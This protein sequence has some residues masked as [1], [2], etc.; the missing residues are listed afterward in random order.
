MRGEFSL[1]LITVLAICFASAGSAG[2]AG[3]KS[4]GKETDKVK[5][6]RIVKWNGDVSYTLAIT[7]QEVDE[8]T[9]KAR[10]EYEKKKQTWDKEKEAFE[11]ANPE[12]KFDKPAPAEP[13]VDVLAADVDRKEAKR[14]QSDMES[15]EWSVFKIKSSPPLYVVAVS[16]HPAIVKCAAAARHAAMHNAWV[17]DGKQGDEPAE[18]EIEALMENLNKA[19]AQK[20]CREYQ[21]AA[22]KE[23]KEAH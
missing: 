6:V 5:L 1:L 12:M 13:K 16:D 2:E 17:K 11:K 10:D 19:K 3:K 18:P 14:R 22:D 21:Q 8:E 15:G 23:A 7:G 4:G 9:K 20:Q